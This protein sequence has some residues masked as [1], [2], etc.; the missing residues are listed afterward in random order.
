MLRN[1][2]K[3]KSVLQAVTNG[4]IK[5]LNMVGN[6]SNLGNAAWYNHNSIANILSLAAVCRVCRVTI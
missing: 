4:G 3:S 6:F 1:N 2:K 5:D